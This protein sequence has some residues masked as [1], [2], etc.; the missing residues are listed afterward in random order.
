MG[1]QT[2]VSKAAAQATTGFT[3]E[4]VVCSLAIPAGALNPTLNGPGSRVHYHAVVVT[5]GG[6]GSDTL[7]AGISTSPTTVQHDLNTAAAG[8]GTRH[9]I[10]DLYV[11]SRGAS[12]EW[13]NG[14]AIAGTTLTTADT[15]ESFPQSAVIYLN[16][17]ATQTVSTD[18]VTCN[19]TQY[20]IY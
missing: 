12:S 17:S 18:T 10:F 3:S 14:F 1:A 11:S 2:T 13:I 4:T 7:F 16:I 9:Y 6:A 20:T 8:T 19:D 15:G 5:T